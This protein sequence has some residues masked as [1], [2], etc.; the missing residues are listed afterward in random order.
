MTRESLERLFRSEEW[1][2]AMSCLRAKR[3]E[4]VQAL[5]SVRP[6]DLQKRQAHI[7]AFD[8][9]LNEFEGHILGTHQKQEARKT[10]G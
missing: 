7:A 6:E 1:R 5:T 4:R 9:I 3:E 8:E 10:N 2:F